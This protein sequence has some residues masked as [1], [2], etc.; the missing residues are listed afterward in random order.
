VDSSG[1]LLVGVGS[2]TADG[3]V[4]EL[5]GGIT[6]P[7]TAV[8]ATNANTLD[9]Y[10]EGTWTPTVAGS[11][12]A[13]T[14]TYSEN[15]GRYTKIGRLVQIELY[16]LWSSGTGT[17]DLRIQGLPFTAASSNTYPAGSIAYL[18]NLTLPANHI[19]TAMIFSASTTIYIRSTPVGGGTAGEA[20]YDSAASII[21]SASY[22]V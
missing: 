21:M 15:S 16:L 1:R 11:S 20:A 5:S 7:A 18:N 17:G 2:A 9:D 3:G 6:F 12:T 14:A 8:A 13:G 19:A 22:S 10:E 4:L